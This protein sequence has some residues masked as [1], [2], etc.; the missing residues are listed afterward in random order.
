[1]PL[2]APGEGIRLPWT[3]TGQIKV[4]GAEVSHPDV[5]GRTRDPDKGRCQ[6]GAS[7]QGGEGADKGVLRLWLK[8]WSAA[9]QL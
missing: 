2:E 7:K 3:E 5:W 6:M 4:M 9:S 8:I 1:M